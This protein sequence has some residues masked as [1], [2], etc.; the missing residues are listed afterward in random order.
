MRTRRTTK[1]QRRF[2]ATCRVLHMLKPRRLEDVEISE[3][4]RGNEL[5]MFGGS[6]E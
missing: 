5:W 2:A 6:N 1:R 3:D 4:E